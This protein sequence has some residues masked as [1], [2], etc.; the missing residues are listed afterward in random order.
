[1]V[2]KYPIKK[3]ELKEKGV[4]TLKPRKIWFDD[5]VQRLNVDGRGELVGE[6]RGEDRLLIINQKGIVKT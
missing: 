2:T 3:I 1:M 4:S 6:F 5:T